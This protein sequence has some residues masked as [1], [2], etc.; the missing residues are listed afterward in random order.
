MRK[1]KE[2][3][4]VFVDGGLDN[5]GQLKDGTASDPLSGSTVKAWLANDLYNIIGAV[6]KASGKSSFDGT[7][8]TVEDS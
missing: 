8:E 3:Q 1:I 5:S 7:P 2:N 4:A 6:I